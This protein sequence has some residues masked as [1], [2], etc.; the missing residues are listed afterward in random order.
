[1]D[2]VSLIPVYWIVTYPGVSVYKTGEDL[3]GREQIQQLKKFKYMYCET[4]E[5]AC[6]LSPV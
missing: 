6:L 4:R 5:S 3:C 1:M 2:T